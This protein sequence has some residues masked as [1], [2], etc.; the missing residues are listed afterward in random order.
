VYVIPPLALVTAVPPAL[1]AA[2]VH[3][4]PLLPH[5]SSPLMLTVS[6]PARIPLLVS[7]TACDIV[8]ALPVSKTTVPPLMNSAPL[9]VNVAPAMIFTVPLAKLTVPAPL[10]FPLREGT[11]VPPSSTSPSPDAALHDPLDVPARL[12]RLNTPELPRTFPVL[13]NAGFTVVVP[14]PPVFSNVP[15]LLNVPPPVVMVSVGKSLV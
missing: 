1:Q 10:M 14:V 11:E 6:G 13:V 8:T 3:I 7:V 9:P 15:A 4:A 12:F 5:V 2:T